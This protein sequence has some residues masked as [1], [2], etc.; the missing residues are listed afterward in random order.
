MEKY[1]PDI[2]QKS[3][4]T[5]NYE[6][7]KNNGIK[8]LLFDLDNT[9]IPSRTTV[10]N[11]KTKQFINDLKKDFKI[12]IFSNA[13]ESRV[14]KIANELEVAHYA[15]SF[16]PLSRTFKKVLSDHRYKECE[17]AIVGDQLYTDIAG[18]NQVGITTILVN[19]VS[20]SDSIFTKLNRYLERRKM[21]KLYRKGL[22]VKGKYY[23]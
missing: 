15:W 6:N 14:E 18:G 9:L 11:D 12:I 13:N 20:N 17:V 5:I 8:C 21:R 2:Y 1:V 22:F 16:K 7:L 19:P 3:I 10:V 4:Y 23:E